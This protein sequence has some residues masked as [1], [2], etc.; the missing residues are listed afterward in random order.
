MLSTSDTLEAADLHLN[1]STAAQRFI[2]AGEAAPLPSRRC[3]RRAYFRFQIVQDDGFVMVET[4][5]SVTCSI[6]VSIPR[7]CSKRLD[8][9]LTGTGSTIDTSEF[10]TMCGHVYAA[11]RVGCSALTALLVLDAKNR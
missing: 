5:G 1:T 7:S 8:R 11:L 3:I 2:K 10:T 4:S 9:P 6:A